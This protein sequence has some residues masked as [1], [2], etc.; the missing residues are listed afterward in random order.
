M[1]HVKQT[2]VLEAYTD[3]KAQHPFSLIR[4]FASHQENPYSQRIF[5]DIQNYLT[6]CDSFILSL[7]RLHQTDLDCDV[8]VFVHCWTG[9]QQRKMACRSPGAE[10][11]GPLVPVHHVNLESLPDLSLFF[12]LLCQLFSG[13]QRR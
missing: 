11:I 2:C 13:G 3:I 7:R 1:G 5:S 8:I 12:Y 9:F 10:L 4:A 6:Y